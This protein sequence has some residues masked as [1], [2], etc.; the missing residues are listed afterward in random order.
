M[1]HPDKEAVNPGISYYKHKVT[2]ETLEKKGTELKV[3]CRKV[4]VSLSD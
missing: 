4:L 1:P 3:L 2:K